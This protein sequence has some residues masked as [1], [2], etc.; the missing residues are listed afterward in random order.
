MPSLGTTAEHLFVPVRKLEVKITKLVTNI[1]RTFTH[2][3]YFQAQE[4]DPER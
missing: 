4:L 1:I 3:P 2:K